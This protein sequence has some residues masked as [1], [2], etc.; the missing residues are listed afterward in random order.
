[1]ISLKVNLRFGGT[2]FSVEK[3]K[4]ETSTEA[5]DVG[6]L[7]GL[8]FDP[9]DGGELFLRNVVW[10]SMD[11]TALYPIIQNPSSEIKV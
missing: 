10:F 7:F 9:E 2:T 3:T 5:G 11:Y 1:V 4:Q 8:L 6:F